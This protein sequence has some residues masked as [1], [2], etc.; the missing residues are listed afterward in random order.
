M[1][2]FASNEF[3]NTLCCCPFFFSLSVTRLISFSNMAVLPA[4][5]NRLM[6]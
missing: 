4:S 2:A 5:F 3:L 1:I 6:I